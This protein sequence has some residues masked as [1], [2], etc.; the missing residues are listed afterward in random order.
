MNAKK[1]L[2]IGIFPDPGETCPKGLPKEMSAEEKG[3]GGNARN[4]KRRGEKKR[5]E[6]GGVKE[7]KKRTRE[8][9]NEGQT[10]ND[11]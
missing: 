5:M 8:Y 2:Q 3:R 10:G 6:K 11:E 9:N 4:G 1:D 7:R